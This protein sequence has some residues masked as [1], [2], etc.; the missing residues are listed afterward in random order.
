[1]L[2]P[3]RELAAALGVSRSTLREAIAVLET[4]GII[5][6]RAN[7][8]IEIA[9]GA[10]SIELPWRRARAHGSPQEQFGAL[11]MI[12]IEVA[13]LASEAEDKSGVGRLEQRLHALKPEV[14][15]A[16]SAHMADFHYELAQLAGNRVFSGWVRELWA[17]TEGP[18]WRPYAPGPR[19]QGDRER[20]LTLHN[21]LLAAIADGRSLV[22]RQRM[23]ACLRWRE[24]MWF[25]RD[26]L[27]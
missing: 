2:P 24:V 8:G 26:A 7:H 14:D 15:D 6:V 22:A 23:G 17:A 4:L 12:G 19:D 13:G 21:R 10:A 16:W 3:E 18:G 1:M 27:R 25:E 20:E 11:R 5:V 9:P